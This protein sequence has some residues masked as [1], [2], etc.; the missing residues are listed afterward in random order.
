M[1]MGRERCCSAAALLR[2]APGWGCPGPAAA[3]CRHAAPRLLLGS[4]VCG[5]QRALAAQEACAGGVCAAR[6][7]RKTQH[8]REGCAAGSAA[9]VQAGRCVQRKREQNASAAA[10]L[11]TSG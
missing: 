7:S 5:R 9:Y 10:A 6:G 1:L 11:R 3:S 2:G 4:C 8:T